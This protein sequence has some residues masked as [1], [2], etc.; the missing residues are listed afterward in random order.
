M[1]CKESRTPLLT[2]VFSQIGYTI[3]TNTQ[4]HTKA[5]MHQRSMRR[6]W[7]QTMVSHICLAVCSSNCSANNTDAACPHLSELLS[8]I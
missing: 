4:E 1:W 2:F 3:H 8:S 7:A 5:W 6:L